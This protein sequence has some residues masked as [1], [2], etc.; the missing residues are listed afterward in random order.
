MDIIQIRETFY[1]LHKLARPGNRFI[2]K[3]PDCINF[4]TVPCG[5]ANKIKYYDSFT[6]I[7][8][9]D[10]ILHVIVGGTIHPF[11]Q[12]SITRGVQTHSHGGYVA[13]RGGKIRSKKTFPVGRRVEDETVFG[14]AS[15]RA[16][17]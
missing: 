10:D 15:L 7:E 3:F 13:I 1:P 14:W 2:N 12:Q 16:M 4:D 9:N 8:T 17:C 11:N 6:K 5:K